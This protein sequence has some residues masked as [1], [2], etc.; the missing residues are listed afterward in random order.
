MS[1]TPLLGDQVKMTQF[2]KTSYEFSCSHLH[3]VISLYGHHKYLGKKYDQMNT[4]HLRNAKCMY[5]VCQLRLVP[6]SYVVFF[7]DF[8]SQKENWIS[9]VFCSF[10]GQTWMKMCSPSCSLHALPQMLSSFFPWMVLDLEAVH[11]YERFFFNICLFVWV[12]FIAS[13]VKEISDLNAG[14]QPSL[15]YWITSIANRLH[16]AIVK[17]WLQNIAC[18]TGMGGG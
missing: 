14:W 8:V 4:R 10:W 3:V 13:Q 18:A 16:A 7:P 2:Q 12:L 17:V 11:Q 5:N 15:F 6:Y 1:Q 9:N